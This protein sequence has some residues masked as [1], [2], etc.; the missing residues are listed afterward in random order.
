[1][2]GIKPKT[3]AISRV[4]PSLAS[5]AL[6]V[7]AL[8]VVALTGCSEKASEPAPNASPT[9]ETSAA[10]SATSV[11]TSEAVTKN[12]LKDAYFGELHLH[13]AYSLDA[14][15]FGNTMNDPFTAYRFAKGGVVKLANG[16]EK[17]ISKPLDFAA[18]TDHSE[19]LGEYEVC[20]NPQQANYASE[21]C[22]GIRNFNMQTFQQLFS[23]MAKTPAARLAD[24]CGEDGSGCINA[25]EGP[26]QRIQQAAAQSYEPGKFT[27]FVAYEFSA[28]APEGAGGMMHRNVIFKND[29]VP[30]TVFS[31][32]EGTGEDLHKWLEGNCIR[33]CKVL[34]IPHNPNFYWGRLYW[35]KNSDGSDF[36]QAIVERRARMDRLVEVMQIKGNS[37]C[38]TGIMT[39][40]EECN[41]ETVFETCAEGE[42]AACSNDYAM[43]RNGLKFGLR[44]QE[45]WGVNPFKQG[46]AGGTDNH[47]GTPS[48]TAEDDFEGHY[49]NNDGSPEVRLGLKANPTAEAMGMSGDDDPTK[50]YNP[51]AITGVWAESNTRE[52]I[53]DA[54]HR[55]ETFATSGTRTKV[56][57]F[58]GYNF[59]DQLHQDAD[60]VKTAYADGVPQGGTLL[61]AANGKVPKLVI[62]AMRDPMSAP[63]QKVQVIKGWRTEED[64]LKEAVFDV[65]CS[66]GLQPDPASHRCPDNGATVNLEDCSISSDKGATELSTT[67]T[68]PGFNPRERA[69]YYVRVLENPV[70]RWSMYDAKKIGVEH[71]QELPK[72]VKERAWSSPVWYTP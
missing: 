46:F 32:F 16:V 55:R 37:E 15:I 20:T 45:E 67:W 70:C 5:S 40:D 13:T 44:E 12:L 19:A 43:V 23:G 69:F 52:D 3:R 17:Q 30:E 7:G 11:T 66:D 10:E 65:A 51:G 64:E 25:I 68:D 33:D 57:M 29:Q 54:L 28:N 24:I 35:G 50:L 59:A 47:N 36:T 6:V 38:Q 72:T 31:A 8:L 1:M 34:T 61:T 21:T 14:Y 62:W 39:T 49:A 42:N 56:R 71:P 63:L 58:A 26:W 2:Q 53:W 60:W 4:F 18:I 48:D 22:E 9:P 41:F 27:S